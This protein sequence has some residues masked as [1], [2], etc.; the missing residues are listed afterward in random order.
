MRRGAFFILS[1]ILIGLRTFPPGG[2][3]DIFSRSSQSR[4]HLRV[5]S[6]HQ[7]SRNK[8]S[9]APTKFMIEVASRIGELR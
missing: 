8:F 9:S 6:G 3:I 7:F 4:A 1:G 5:K 2:D